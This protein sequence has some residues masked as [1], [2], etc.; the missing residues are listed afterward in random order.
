MPQRESGKVNKLRH[1]DSFV[2]I[3]TQLKFF[4]CCLSPF[5]Y[6]SW[7]FLKEVLRLSLNYFISLVERSS[8]SHTRNQFQQKI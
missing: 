3:K 2:G 7:P 5:D 6:G 1:G 8:P 4:P